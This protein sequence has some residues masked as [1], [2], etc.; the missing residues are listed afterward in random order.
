MLSL[1]SVP[2]DTRPMICLLALLGKRRGCFGLPARHAGSKG[3]RQGHSVPGLVV[4]DAVDIEGRCPVDPASH[5]THEVIVDPLVVG[6]LLELG[7]K[8]RQA[9]TDCRRMLEQVLERQPVLVLV[10][11]VMHLPEAV[12]I[13]RSLRRFGGQFG[14]RMNRRYRKVTKDKAHL[15]A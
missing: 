9:Q 14:V 4:A 12:L 15:L 6:V 7:L 10:E 11:T 3:G 13:A 5:A 1:F 8:W 2:T